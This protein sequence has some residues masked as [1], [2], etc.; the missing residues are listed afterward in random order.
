MISFKTWLWDNIISHVFKDKIK[1]E[2]EYYIEDNIE[3]IMSDKAEAYNIGVQE[4]YD[5]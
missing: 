1:D 2:I 4:C 5:Y 3:G